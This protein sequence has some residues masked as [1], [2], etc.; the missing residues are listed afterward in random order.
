MS[1]TPRL[2]CF[3]TSP[4][5]SPEKYS[6][7]IP[8]SAT[9]WPGSAPRSLLLQTLLLDVDGGALAKAGEQRFVLRAAVELRGALVFGHLLRIRVDHFGD[10]QQHVA[11]P[12]YG[13]AH[14][15]GKLG[16]VGRHD[17]VEHLCRH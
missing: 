3:P 15:R 11:R 12:G 14:V 7:S 4:P 13:N 17:L 10:L 16:D 8:A 9:S 6:T 1:A 2:S 5:R